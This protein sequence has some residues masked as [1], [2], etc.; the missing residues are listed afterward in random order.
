MVSL[1]VVSLLSILSGIVFQCMRIVSTIYPVT[2]R[3]CV[4]QS[5]VMQMCNYWGNSHKW[6][7]II[8][9]VANRG[10]I[11]WYSC[12][13]IDT[14]NFFHCSLY[15]HQFLQVIL[16][17]GRQNQSVVQI[18]FLFALRLYSLCSP[19]PCTFLFLAPCKIIKSSKLSLYHS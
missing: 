9:V 11:T 3:S 15:T 13:R 10:N 17:H 1:I 19:V 4:M 6:W 2:R 7:E 12:D 16:N 14:W 5:E 18:L 8:F